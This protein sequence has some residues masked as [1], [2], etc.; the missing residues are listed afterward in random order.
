MTIPNRSV[1]DW[2]TGVTVYKPEKCFN[3]YTV[4]NPY[5]AGTIFLIDMVGQVVHAW[6]AHP[7]RIAES[8]FLRRLANGHWM[9]LVFFQ[10]KLAE[11]NLEGGKGK[12][13]G[14]FS[15]EGLESAVLELDWE[16]RAVWEFHAPAAWSMHHD[17]ARLR[18]GNT[19]VLANQKVPVESVSD[20]PIS[21][22]FIIEV[23]PDREVVWEWRA[24]DHL[25][26]FGFCEEG[27]AEIRRRGGDVYHINTLS[28]L[29]GN[30]LERQDSRFA[31]GNIL[32]CQR[33]SNLIYI[34]DKRSGAVVW[35][36]GMEDLVGPHHPEMLA[37]GN[38][39]VYDN[40][41]K[42]GHPA[43]TRFCTRLV[44]VAPLTGKIVWQ[45]AHEPQGF[46]ETAKFFS[47]SWGSV[48]RLPNGN[49]F[50]L[51]CHKGRLFEVT[52]SGEIVW[53]Y[54]NP[55]TWGRGTQLTDPGVYRAY[56]YAYD[57]VPE[58]KPIYRDRDGHV[59]VRPTLAPLPAGLGL[60]ATDLP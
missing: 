27:V 41:G 49:T 24:S 20:K 7:D 15:E 29:P 47:S 32:G 9:N 45:Y 38:I 5:R 8:W 16:G 18:N 31:K 33:S 10:P 46:K 36:W 22:N 43:R 3:G 39:L 52:P 11:R 17:M 26:E 44:E 12:K 14:R 28:P 58:A 6:H 2:P 56:R 21:E 51:D 25:E 13:S 4:V 53:E 35:T 60:P 59:G 50:S 34:I 54:I 19:L 42:G 40:G 57:E 1:L 37:N 23:N 55:F 30:D 48:Q